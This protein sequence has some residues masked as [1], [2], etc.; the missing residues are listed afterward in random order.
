MN[1]KDS[2]VKKGHLHPMTQMIREIQTIFQE[3]GFEVAQGPEL[4]TELFVFEK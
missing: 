1:P 2:I 3:I 4:E